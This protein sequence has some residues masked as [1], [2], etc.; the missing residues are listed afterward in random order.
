MIGD[1]KIIE[2][3]KKG[4]KSAQ[5]RLY[6]KYS[7]VML[8]VCLR[9]CSNMADAEDVLQEGFIKVFTYIKNFRGDGSFEG[10]VR[11]IMVNTAI[12][13]IKKNVK[14][15]YEDI[16]NISS[17]YQEDEEIAYSP[18]NPEIMIK[19]LQSLPAGY[20]SVV[21]LYIFE[22]YSHKEIGGIMG[23]SEST[24]KS[25][26]SKAKK[27]IRRKLEEKNLILKTVTSNG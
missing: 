24:S 14:Y 9:Y 21:N 16:E 4:K 25:Q 5:N 1:D 23:I 2:G 11:R 12:T 22:G 6:E 17:D 19:V 8:G 3:C 26:L 27:F 18:V 10:W 7:P 13:H 15:S 20:R